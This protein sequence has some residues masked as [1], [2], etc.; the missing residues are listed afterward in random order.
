MKPTASEEDDFLAN[1]LQQVDNING[2]SS[3]KPPQTPDKRITAATRPVVEDFDMTTFLEGAED[4]GLDDYTISPVKQA[5]PK[6]IPPPPPQYNPHP[7]TRVIVK[8][9][10]EECINSRWR[11]HVIADVDTTEENVSIYLYD[12]WYHCEVM[13]NDVCNVI[14]EFGPPSESTSGA[15]LTRCISITSQSNILILHPDILLTATALSNAPQCRRKPILSSLVRSTSDTTPALVWGNLLHEVM[16]RC[17]IEENWSEKFIDTSIEAAICQSLGELV[18]I[19][20]SEDIAKREVKDRAKGLISFAEKY[21]CDEPQQTAKLTNTRSRSQDDPS[22]LAITKILD[23]EEDIWSPTYGLKGKIDAT[24]Q[25][26]IID[27]PSSNTP[28][29]SSTSASQ[30][31]IIHTPLP[32]ELKTGRAVAGMEHR[33]QTMLYTILVTER[34]GVDVQDG[35]LFYTQSQGEVSRVPR[36]KHELRGLIGA[37]NE[38]AAYMWRRIRAEGKQKLSGQHDLDYENP[39]SLTIQEIE[40]FL[41]P[42]IDDER[43]CARCYV[44]DTCFLFRKTHPDHFNPMSLSTN[45]ALKFNPPVPSYLQGLFD[46]KTGHLTQAQTKFF[47]DWEHLL[48]LEERDLV[49]FKKELWTMGAAEREKRGRCFGGM[50]LAENPGKRPLSAHSLSTT[51]SGGRLESSI[52]KDSKIHRFTYTFRRS[53]HW[54]SSLLLSGHLNAGDPITVSAEPLLALARG[55]ILELTSEEVVLGVDHILDVEAIRNRLNPEQSK[56][57]SLFTPNNTSALEVLFRIDKDELFGGMARVRNNL[58]HMFYA[59]GDRRRLQLVVDLKPPVFSD[60]FPAFRPSPSSN[61]NDCQISAMQKVLSA[62]DYALILGMPGTGKTTVIAALIR[63]LVSRGKTVLLTSYTH[64]AVDT[65]LMKLAEVDGKDSEG[66]QFGIL[67]LGNV[68]KIHPEVRRYTLGAKKS[69]ANVEEY[70]RQIM[71]PPVVATTCLSIEQDARKGGLDISLFRRLSEAHPSA[72]VDLN[73]QYRMN[74]DIMLLSN[75]LIYDN[76]LRCGSEAVAKQALILNDKEFIDSLHVYSNKSTCGTE[77]WLDRLANPKCK[78]VFVDTDALPAQD[79]RI[80]DLVQNITEAELV[81]QFTETLLQSGIEESQIGVISLYRQQVKLLQNLLQCR[82]G[83]E[84]LTADRSQGRDKDVIVISLVRSNDE[85]QIGDLL[86]DW[87]RMN[88]SFT[89]AKK[90]LVL[91]GSRTTLQAE[92]MLSQFFDLMESRHWIVELPAGADQTHAKAFHEQH[93]PTSTPTLVE[94]PVSPI[95]PISKRKR[96][97]KENLI[98][99]TSIKSDETTRP[100]KKMKLSKHI[101]AEK[102]IGLLKG[103]PILH[104][105]ARYE[106]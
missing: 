19:G 33:A 61:L 99:L 85:G 67:R 1:I 101:E 72:I 63:E 6:F 59:D 10:S 11:K 27:P 32:F 8:S 94:S 71:N 100:V 68:D 53:D 70:E 77:C 62:E 91:F 18:K 20:L 49:R 23:I 50:V 2:V 41:P 92:P 57:R 39:A 29:S 84:V 73:Q 34:Y 17:L 89:R 36:G 96:I 42:P 35:L 80:G 65:I 98:R 4:W 47:R 28:L 56:S 64:S 46:E 86:K 22:L 79:S 5:K 81:Y 3:V 104:D 75:Y 24:V 44:Q 26:I 55:Y 87:R 95:Q 51:D 7:C 30:R 38:I 31:N 88:V 52:G 58:A 48:A 15:A 90:K 83:V 21:L 103:R 14:G 60:P 12:D 76:R 66:A 13:D 9:V 106:Y 43:A 97:G 93:D 40:P 69:A 54:F 25:G 45:N 74:A 37:R 82:P 105:L 16:Q 102:S 78:A